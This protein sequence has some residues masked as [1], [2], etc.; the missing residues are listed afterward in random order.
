MFPQ[1]LKVNY[2]GITFIP[3]IQGIKHCHAVTVSAGTVENWSVNHFFVFFFASLFSQIASS[4]CCV[5]GNTRPEKGA[6]HTGC[7]WQPPIHMLKVYMKGICVYAVMRVECNVTVNLVKGQSDT[8]QVSPA[9]GSLL[10]NSLPIPLYVVCSHCFPY[11][12]SSSC[13]TSGK[14]DSACWYVRKLNYK[15]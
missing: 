1:Y 8:E 10:P 3:L 15:K 11:I 12:R 9:Y 7:Q 4:Y 14:V 6:M 13:K 5:T 2:F